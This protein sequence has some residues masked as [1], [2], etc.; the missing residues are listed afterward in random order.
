MNEILNVG[1]IG[2]GVIAP[3]HID[4]YAALEGV[5]VRGVC[6]L[7]PQRIQAIRQRYPELQLEAYDSAERLLADPAID[8]VSICTDHA[9]HET[10]LLEAISAGK[11]VI[12]EKALTINR[13]SLE[14]MV[15]AATDAPVITAGILQHRFDPV[16]RV[17]RE[18][19]GEGLLGR[20]L[21][22]SAQHQ[23]FR[24]NAYYQ[25][26]AWRGTW[27]GEG[28]SLLINQSIHFLDILQWVAGGVASVSG[29]TANL[30]HGGIIET[31]DNAAV[32]LVLK[33]GALGTFTATSG[34]HRTWE[35]AFQVVGTEGDIHLMNGN[36]SRCGHRDPEIA[37]ALEGRLTKLEEQ[38]G[39]EGAKAYYG[40][41]H[42]AQIRDFV[43]AIRE[44][45]KPFVD[46]AD[47]REAV[48]LVLAIYESGR[49]NRPI[50][51]LPAPGSESGRPASGEGGRAQPWSKGPASPS[52]GS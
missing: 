17:L 13:D 25:S 1:I 24:S 43:E 46:L 35:C 31:E 29:H 50:S 26:D 3:S 8:A 45:R 9:S 34:C 51:L 40:T 5:R 15:S 6:D 12:C 4:S 11:H 21:T 14:R 2:C 41:S 27:E 28:G 16:Y 22:I 7:L 48:E 37:E 52:R 36:L 44:Q 32:S 19:I 49:L 47:A 38:Q 42:P 33:N 10:L 30:A 20:L 39:V 18:I 23:C